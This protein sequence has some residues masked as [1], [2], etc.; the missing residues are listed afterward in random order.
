[1]FN[2]QKDFSSVVQKIPEVVR[3][4]P[5]FKREVSYEKSETGFRFVLGRPDDPDREIVLTVLAFDVPGRV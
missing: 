3:I 1:M 5:A 4:H 2:K